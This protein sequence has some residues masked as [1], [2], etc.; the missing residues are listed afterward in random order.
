MC[1]SVVPDMNQVIVSLRVVQV[2][3]PE[4]DCF[5]CRLF[6][7]N[8][9]CEHEAPSECIYFAPRAESMRILKVI[10]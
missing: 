5:K 4:V 7:P 1:S 9:V 2:Q 3:A 10:E 6:N 8:T